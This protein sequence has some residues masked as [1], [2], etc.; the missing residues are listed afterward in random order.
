MSDSTAVTSSA[1]ADWG[2]GDPMVMG[3]LYLLV[4][5]SV[6][7]W[8]MIVYKGIELWRAK[9]ANDAYARN[10][11]ASPDAV[12]FL[13]RSAASEPD[14]PLAELTRTGVST[15]RH[16][17]SHYADPGDA[18]KHIGNIT[19]AITR[20]LRQ[21]IQ[22]QVTRFDAGLGILA[23]IGNI[24]PF[25]GLFGTVIG[26]MLALKGIAGS[27]SMDINVVA[28]PIGEALVATAAGI[29]CAIPAV[30]AY[31]SFVRRMK[32]FANTL[33]SFAYDL[34]SHLASG[35][36]VHALS[37]LDSGADHQQEGKR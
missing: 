24:A 32:V 12:Q 28:G 11:W 31:N 20:A 23:T 14:C 18:A 16:Y 25:I 2:Q 4:G 30:V 13:S 10:F 17:Q 29:A 27:G 22:D 6:L 7:T 3:V 36:A 9:R 19:D 8:F 21:S 1:I 35:H 33:D 5:L 26:I 37:A 34:L 15:V